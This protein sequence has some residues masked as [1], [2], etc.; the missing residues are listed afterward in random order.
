MKNPYDPKLRKAAEE[1]NL[2]CQ[3]YDCVGVCLFVSPTH[4]EFV[5][6]FSP[7]WSVMKME[8][9]DRLR[10]R[11]KK[12]DFPSDEDQKF[13]TESTV[14]AVTSILE[15]SVLLHETWAK[16]LLHLRGH[17]TILHSAWGEPDSVPGDG[18]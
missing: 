16:L 13:A 17:M 8:G 15:W 3:K 14:H 10:F 12:E 7:S 9:D 5:N 11:S 4:S 1:F 2:L 18:K 6:H